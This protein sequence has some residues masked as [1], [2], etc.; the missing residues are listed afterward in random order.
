MY[1]NN[2]MLKIIMTSQSIQAAVPKYHILSG[3]QTTEIYLSLSWRLGSPS[4]RHQQ[5]W[6]LVSTPFLVHRYWSYCCILMWQKGAREMS[7][8]S[9]IRALIQIIRVPSSWPTYLPKVLPPNTITLGIRFPH[10]NFGRTPTFS[11]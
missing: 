8:T 2:I 4:S 3:L 9:V 11:L 6:W 5:I 10:I 1:Q 7:G